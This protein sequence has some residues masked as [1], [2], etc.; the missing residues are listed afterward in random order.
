VFDATTTT[1]DSSLGQCIQL[2]TTLK[3]LSVTL[4]RTRRRIKETRVEYQLRLKRLDQLEE[5]LTTISGKFERDAMKQ[6][7]QRIQ[8]DEEEE[9][10][11]EEEDEYDA[12][13]TA[14]NKKRKRA[15]HDQEPPKKRGWM[16]PVIGVAVP[17]LAWASTVWTEELLRYMAAGNHPPPL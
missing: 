16:W 15:G 13:V 10:E 3:E 11:E 2:R 17:A 9:E 7:K 8:S 12:P 6:L 1:T 5:E 4:E 14:S